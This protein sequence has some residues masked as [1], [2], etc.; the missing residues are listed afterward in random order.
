MMLLAIDPGNTESA[1]CLM[2]ENHEVHDKG[3]VLNARLIDYIMLNAKRI[4]HLAV[5]MVASMGMP[6]GAE[7]FETC[8]MIGRIEL[9]ADMKGIA[10]SRVYRLEEKVRICHDSRAKDVNIRRALIER[11]ARHDRK[12]GK[13]TKTNPDHFYGFKADVWSAFAVGVVH[14]EKRREARA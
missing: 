1:F 11:F 4:D 14:L 9:T 6:V 8:V 7:V 3:K 13:G 2:D 5:E 12:N 10:H